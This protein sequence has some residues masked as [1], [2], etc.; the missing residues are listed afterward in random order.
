MGTKPNALIDR[1]RT[2]R[3]AIGAKVKYTTQRFGSVPA[4]ASRF[5]CIR[6]KPGYMLNMCRVIPMIQTPASGILVAV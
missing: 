6:I 5:N 3:I 4:S 1:F 2:A